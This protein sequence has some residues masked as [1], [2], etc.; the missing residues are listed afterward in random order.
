MLRGGQAVDAIDPRTGRRGRMMMK[1]AHKQWVEIVGAVISEQRSLGAKILHRD[2]IGIN[3]IDTR[4]SV[5]K[6]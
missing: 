5:V 1:M 2:T 3:S 4:L 6:R